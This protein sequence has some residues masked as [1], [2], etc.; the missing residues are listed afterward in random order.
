MSDLRRPP[1]PLTWRERLRARVDDLRERRAAGR[2]VR[3]G[4]VL[5][6]DAGVFPDPRA[7]SGVLV[8][9]AIVVGAV[10]MTFGV[11]W[12]IRSWSNR[13][14]PLIDDQLPLLVDPDPTV[15]PP[16]PATESSAVVDAAPQATGA[17]G[18]QSGTSEKSGTG[19][20]S[21]G[22]EQ[23]GAEESSVVIVHVAGAVVEPGVVEL[24]PGS[25]VYQA[26]EGAGGVVEDADLDRVNLAAV[27]IDGEQLHIPRIGQPLADEPVTPERTV[28]P[29]ETSGGPEVGSIDLNR[30]SDV[31]LQQLPGIG[32]TIARAIV[33]LREMRGPYASVNELLLVDGIGEAKLEAIR[34][35]VVVAS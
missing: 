13:S 24:A 18:E 27:V 3:T 8:V 1:A 25:R 23:R 31:E 34:P 17:A 35:F 28:L 4:G 30:A 10:L 7:G 9:G 29:D 12:G 15:D 14:A 32:P 11:V 22:G 20:Q 2:G 26:I 33:E 5:P 16:E 19:E 21:R 6:A